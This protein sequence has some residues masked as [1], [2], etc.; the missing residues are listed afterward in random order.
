[1][2]AAG[3]A[4]PPLPGEEDVSGPAPSGQPAGQEPAAGPEPD[5]S[6]YDTPGTVTTPMITAVWTVL[7][8]VFKFTKDEKDQA[9]AVCAHIIE[10]DLASTTDMSKNEAK[11][12]LDTLA[13][14]QALAEERSMTPREL[15]VELMAI[16][17]GQEPADA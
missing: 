3:E 6:D 8:T 2:P 13:Y 10:H 5:D 4:L 7:S 16:E 12:V 14:W 9:R 15:L 1:V 11:T 17:A